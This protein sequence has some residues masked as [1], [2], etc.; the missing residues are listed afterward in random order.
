MTVTEAP[1]RPPASRAADAPPPNPKDLTP[2][3]GRTVR[4]SLFWVGVGV[5]ALLVA[6]AGLG[7]Q[8]SSVGGDPLSPANPAPAGSKALVEVLRDQGVQVEFTQS[9]DATVDAVTDFEA[10]TLVIYDPEAVLTAFQ[11]RKAARLAEHVVIVDPS[12]DQLHEVAP[13]ID[14]SGVVP[15][16]LDAECDLPAA[17]RAGEVSGESTGYRLTDDD[18]GAS[19]CFPSGSG[20]YSLIQLPSSGSTT[21]DAPAQRLTVLGTWSALS[22]ETITRSGN[23][24]LA[25]N[26]LG[27]HEDLVWYIPGIADFDGSGGNAAAEATPE[28]LTPAIIL[29]LIAGLAAAVW[30]G[31]RLGPLVIENLPVTVR[32][33]ETMLGRARLYERSGS[34]LRALD[35]L[36]IGTV[37]RL[38]R[39]SGLS[40]H[41][42]LDEIVVAVAALSGRPPSEVRALLL[43]REPVTDPELVQLSDDLLT[44]ER[45]VSRAARP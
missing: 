27:E 5:V 35:A 24:A 4:R 9:L 20:V 21:S 19:T 40:R 39:A 23:A 45:D 33:S 28:W 42:T 26:L 31:R 14:R 10:T 44:L 17:A 41:A 1:A 25:L 36:R 43:D 2:T 13:E 11:L 6:I 3:V 8:G 38:A 18:A 29:L 15:Q 30:R 7:L 22:N 16:N 34:R 12:D 32:A 37:Q